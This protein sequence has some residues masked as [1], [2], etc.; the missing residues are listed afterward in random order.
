MQREQGEEPAFV[1]E[2]SKRELRN[3]KKAVKEQ[4]QNSDNKKSAFNQENNEVS[5]QLEESGE[6]HERN[7]AKKCVC[8]SKT[9]NLI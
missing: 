1:D 3:K 9:K 7:N 4:Q 2:E 6:R 5:K 8:V